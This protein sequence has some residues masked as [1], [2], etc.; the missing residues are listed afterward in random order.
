ME[1]SMTKEKIDEIVE[2]AYQRHRHHNP[3][4][5]GLI[6]LLQ[7]VQNEIGYL[8]R[9]AL[10]KTSELMDIPLSH[11]YGVATFFHQFRLR[12]K[13]K[14]IITVC[15]GTACHV[16]GSGDLINILH[17]T[18]KLRDGEDTTKDGL[19]TV[20]QVRCLGACG[21]APIMKVDEEFYG[22]MNAVGLSRI[23]NKYRSEA[24]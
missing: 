23:L 14:H 13:G 8:P 24:S 10:Q 5:S 7:E 2:R 16:Q 19:F 15:R 21:L 9:E 6:I 1:N 11:I 3:L 4:Q 12:P 18:L 20:M 17:Q 22:K